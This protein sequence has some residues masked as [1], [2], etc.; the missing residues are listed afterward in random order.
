MGASRLLVLHSGD[1]AVRGWPGQKSPTNAC[2]LAAGRGGLGGRRR[3]N[4]T[5]NPADR[6]AVHLD[7][8]QTWNMYAYVRNNPTTLTDPSGL[9]LEDACIVE[10]LFLLGA[11]ATTTYLASPA[12]QNALRNTEQVIGAVG[13][14]I[15][16]MLGSAADTQTATIHQKSDQPTQGSET[17]RPEAEEQPSV[18]GESTAERQGAQDKKLS[19]SEAG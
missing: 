6:N 13:Q 12:G 18:E 4:V 7:D 10:G 5:S 11:Y 14:S 17:R 1:P 15:S 9:C 2:L 19:S 3:G 16:K 8:P